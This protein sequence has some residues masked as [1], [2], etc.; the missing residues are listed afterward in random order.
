MYLAAEYG[1]VLPMALPA[2]MFV[3]A[4]V[5]AVFCIW[6]GLKWDS[7]MFAGLMISV[8][9]CVFALLPMWQID[10]Q[11]AYNEQ[12]DMLIYSD[13]EISDDIPEG[14]RLL[15][16]GGEIK[17]NEYYI[18]F[19]CTTSD[20]YNYSKEIEVRIPPSLRDFKFENYKLYA[21]RREPTER[22]EPNPTD[23]VQATVLE[24]EIENVT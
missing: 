4:G 11:V 3:F 20:T 2:G 6:A 15:K 18:I 17:D 22:I 19:E 10:E 5:I 9:I 16:K 21:M 7:E 14:C 1:S 8:L 12:V 23:N 24:A 13:V